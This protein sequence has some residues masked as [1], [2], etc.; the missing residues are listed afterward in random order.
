M[1][2]PVVA[3]SPPSRPG[4]LLAGGHEPMSVPLELGIAGSYCEEGACLDVP[5]HR[6]PPSRGGTHPTTRFSCRITCALTVD[7][8]DKDLSAVGVTAVV[9]VDTFAYVRRRCLHYRFL[10]T[11]LRSGCTNPVKP[12]LQGGCFLLGIWRSPRGN[13]L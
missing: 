13:P 7:P 12:A 1:P 2:P 9:D 3:S 10:I 11:R 4:P 8:S 5:P 6:S